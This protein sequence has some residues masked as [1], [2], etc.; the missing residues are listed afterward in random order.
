[1]TS[2][3]TNTS[4]AHPTGGATFD[5]ATWLQ[6]FER[7]GGYWIVTEGGVTLGWYLDG[8]ETGELQA[9]QL[10]SELKQDPGK[11]AAVKAHIVARSGEGAT[12]SGDSP[13]N[14]RLGESAGADAAIIDA[15]ERRVAAYARINASRVDDTDEE[16]AEEGAWAIADACDRLIQSTIAETARGIEIQVWT[17]LHNSSAYLVEDEQAILRQDL[18]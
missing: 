6:H 18:A 16:R 8:D 7:N 4:S 3:S 13:N 17:A 9:R 12:M 14:E 2:D 15:W 11:N 5:P 1:M 10:F